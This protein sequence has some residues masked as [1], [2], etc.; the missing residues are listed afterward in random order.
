MSLEKV[1]KTA[2]ARARAISLKEIKDN[3][4]KSHLPT[5]PDFVQIRGI[6]SISDALQDEATYER[7]RNSPD[8]LGKFKK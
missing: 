4:S 7:L 6:A 1:L 8:I 5:S 3:S 2:R